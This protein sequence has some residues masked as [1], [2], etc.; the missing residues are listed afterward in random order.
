MKG[1]LHT[2]YENFPNF[3]S[4]T[5]IWLWYREILVMQNVHK[6]WCKITIVQNHNRTES[7]LS[8]FDI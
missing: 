4:I 8:Q 5:P 1:H 3:Q 6:G 7:Q 2:Y